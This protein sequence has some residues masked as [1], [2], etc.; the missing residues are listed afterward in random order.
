MSQDVYINNSF[1]YVWICIRKNKIQLEKSLKGEEFS[2]ISFIIYQVF[3]I[4][5]NYTKSKTKFIKELET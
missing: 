3:I 2:Y 4:I 1:Q 5:Q